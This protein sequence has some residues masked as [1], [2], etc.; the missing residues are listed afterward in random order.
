MSEENTRIAPDPTRL[1]QDE[2]DVWRALKTIGEIAFTKVAIDLER[3]AAISGAEFGVLSRLEE[4]GGGLAQVDLA[5]SMDWDKARLSKQ[6][7]R[8]ESRGFVRRKADGRNVVIHVLAEGK[9]ALARARP[10]H[11]A[12]IRQRLLA[13]ISR[14]EAAFLVSLESR[15]SAT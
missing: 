11:Q 7:T 14:E 9:K 3:E 5:R 6:L 8:M 15:L 4:S 2:A 1:S 12:S 13:H 10:I